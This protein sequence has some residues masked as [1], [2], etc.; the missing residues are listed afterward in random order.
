M[1]K[2]EFLNPSKM[3]MHVPDFF[4]MDSQKTHTLAQI[5]LAGESL[6][7]SDSLT[8]MD[9]VT[10]WNQFHYDVLDDRLAKKCLLYFSF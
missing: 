4:K 7:D 3:E 6:P 1:F 5:V 8:C 9:K 10:L 2:R